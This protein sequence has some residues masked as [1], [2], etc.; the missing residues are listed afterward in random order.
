MMRAGNATYS[1]ASSERRRAARLQQ[2][3]EQLAARVDD[4]QVV[5][6]VVV[7]RQLA[8]RGDEQ[9][10]SRS[11]RGR[12]DAAVQ[13]HGVAASTRD[14]HQLEREDR[15]AP[16]RDVAVEDLHR[17]VSLPPPRGTAVGRAVDAAS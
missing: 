9:R 17:R 10:P 2:P 1:A 6:I 16:G 7:E 11:R 13:V 8:E 12:V 14:E 5:E 15:Q 3:D 4:R